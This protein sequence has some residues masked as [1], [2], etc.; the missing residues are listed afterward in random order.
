VETWDLPKIV[1]VHGGPITGYVA[2]IGHKW[3]K[4][5]EFLPGMTTDDTQLT[6][7]TMEG[8]ISG[9]PAA[10]AEQN[11]D[12]YMDA[13]AIAHVEA[14]KLAVGWGTSTTE[15]VRR[16]ANGVHWSQS[17]K[18][19]EKNRG[20]GNGVPMKNSPLAAW[21]SSPVGMKWFEDDR[22][23]FNQRLVDFS[24][25]THYSAV[26]A[27]A[28]VIHANVMHFLLCDEPGDSALGKQVLDLVA[29]AVWG[30]RDG[31]GEK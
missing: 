9:H 12:R 10:V 7:A 24:A 2:P 25:M 16:I 29:D 20:T 22:F 31:Q 5:D 30:W 14:R 15:A 21:A 17:G 11:F 1:E 27:E 23:Q 18:T 28:S 4:T 26:S 3:F 8:L 6:V 19:S 13:I